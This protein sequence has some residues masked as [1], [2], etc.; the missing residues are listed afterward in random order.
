[1]ILKPI[2]EKKFKGIVLHFILWGGLLLLNFLIFGMPGLDFDFT[3]PLLSWLIYIILFYINY[4][5]LVPRF[6]FKKRFLLYVVLLIFAFSSSIYL[7]AVIDR[8]FIEKRGNIFRP[9]N[10]E[11]MKIADFRPET[12]FNEGVFPPRSRTSIP[13]KR[14][15]FFHVNPFFMTGL[16]QLTL[17]LLASISLRFIKKWQ[18]DEK[19]KEDIDK[20]NISTELSFLRQQINPHFLF[21][22]IN[23]IYSLS[24]SQ[25]PETSDA[26]L[27]LSSILRYMLYET[28]KQYVSLE[29]EI[30]TIKDYIELQNLRLTDKVKLNFFLKGQAGNYKIVP[31]VMLPLIENAFKHGVD[32][33]NNS[34][35]DILIEIE[36]GNLIL[37]IRN[38]IVERKQNLESK[39]IGIKNIIRRLELLYPDSYSLNS[40]IQ[41]DVF[42]VLLKIKLEK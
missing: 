13:P 35:I 31:L 24:I 2:R 15:L 8:H 17:I 19:L 12:H 9:V 5:L 41:G 18:D 30:L 27:K 16:L 6:L 39:G 23:S 7:K 28:D 11:R 26:I 3:F 21:N 22:A 34:F 42:K 4:S 32:N 37:T 14:F 1:M 25:R 36:E 20:E 38:K 29:K 33:V 10:I 40:T